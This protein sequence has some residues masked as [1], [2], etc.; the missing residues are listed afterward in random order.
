MQA[1]TE[2]FI[3]LGKIFFII[4]AIILTAIMLHCVNKWMDKS[5]EVDEPEPVKARTEVYTYDRKGRI[6]KGE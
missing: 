6:V 3:V 1:W 4:L 5:G 2:F